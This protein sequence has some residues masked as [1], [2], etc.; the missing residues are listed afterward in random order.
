MITTLNKESHKGKNKYVTSLMWDVKYDTNKL[1]YETETDS[2]IQ[3]SD[4]WLPGRR[5]WRKELLGVWG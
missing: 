1:I 2:Q 5:G 3:R 4:L